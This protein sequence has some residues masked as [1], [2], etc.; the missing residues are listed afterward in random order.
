MFIDDEAVERVND[1]MESAVMAAA[2]DDG[3]LEGLEFSF[4]WP[5]FLYGQMVRELKAQ[6]AKAIGFDIFFSEYDRRSPDTAVTSSRG[7]F[8]SRGGARGG[9]GE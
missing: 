3:N 9:S 5:R 6:G 8:G 4:P 7:G 2:W 1:G